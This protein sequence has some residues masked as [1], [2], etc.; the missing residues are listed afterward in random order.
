MRYAGSRPSLPISETV[1]GLSISNRPTVFLSRNG[2]SA[3]ICP[4]P[5]WGEGVGTTDE[6][7]RPDCEKA[8]AVVLMTGVFGYFGLTAATMRR[9]RRTFDWL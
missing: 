3:G 1:R 8:R 2:C 6:V 5:L 7:P 4:T 9:S